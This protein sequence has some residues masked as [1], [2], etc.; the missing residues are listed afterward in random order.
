MQLRSAPVGLG[1]QGASPALRPISKPVLSKVACL[2]PNRH[3]VGI[4]ASPTPQQPGH[5]TPLAPSVLQKVQLSEEQRPS[6]VPQA[7]S[8][9]GGAAADQPREPP[10]QWGA[11]MKSACRVC[12]CPCVSCQGFLHHGQGCCNNTLTHTLHS[13]SLCAARINGCT[14]QTAFGCYAH[15]RSNARPA[16]ARMQAWASA[17]RYPWCCG[18]AR[19]QQESA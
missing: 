16:H 8:T 15:A 4:P 7:Q 6:V 1:R 18:S 11:D 5:A 13:H 12:V 10:F 19:L 2:Q 9:G 3:S 17:W 14:R